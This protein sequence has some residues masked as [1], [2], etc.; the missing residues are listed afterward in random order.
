MTGT[1]YESVNLRGIPLL[2][3]RGRM[4][5]GVCVCLCVCLSVMTEMQKPGRFIVLG[6]NKANMCTNSI[7]MKEL[8]CLSSKWNALK[9]S[10]PSVQEGD[11]VS[12]SEWEKWFSY[13][14]TASL[15]DSS[16]QMAGRGGS[17]FL[18]MCCVVS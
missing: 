12:G 9:A 16:G 8:V 18:I 3:E 5:G 4:K 2:K 10:G 1:V 17:L 13:N 14:S 6:Q 7:V 11:G 15:K